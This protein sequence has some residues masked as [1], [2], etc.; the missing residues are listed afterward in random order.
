MLIL[1]QFLLMRFFFNFFFELFLHFLVPENSVV[2]VVVDFFKQLLRLVIAFVFFYTLNYFG[3]KSEQI[4]QN[5]NL[6][7]KIKLVAHV[8]EVI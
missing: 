6:I 7:F 3:I 2:S 4:Y 5:K 1:W 8:D